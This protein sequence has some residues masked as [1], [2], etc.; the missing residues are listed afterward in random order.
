MVRTRSHEAPLVGLLAALAAF[1]ALEARGGQPYSIVGQSSAET[2]ATG[3]RPLAERI[4]SANRPIRVAAEEELAPD[5]GLIPSLSGGATFPPEK[6]W[7]PTPA[8]IEMPAGAATI[9]VVADEATAPSEPAVVPPPEAAALAANPTTTDDAGFIDE[10]SSIDSAATASEGLQA[11]ASDEAEAGS[12]VASAAPVTP[13]PVK[14]LPPRRPQAHVTPQRREALLARLRAA[15]ADMPHPLGIVPAAPRRQAMPRQA[16][17]TPRHP[18]PVGSTPLQLAAVPEAAMP[19]AAMPEIAASEAVVEERGI[20]ADETCSSDEVPVDATLPSTDGVD[21]LVSAEA[22]NTEGTPATCDAGT[23][24][25]SEEPRD[26]GLTPEGSVAAATLPDESAEVVGDAAGTAGEGVESGAVGTTTASDEGTIL[27]AEAS[28]VAVPRPAAPSRQATAGAHG[29]RASGQRF[30]A[31]ATIVQRSGAL[32]RLQAR[33]ESIP[34]PLGLLP[35]PRPS[36]HAGGAARAQA[37]VARVAPPAQLQ[38]KPAETLQ[39]PA[40]EAVAS[41]EASLA[42]AVHEEHATGVASAE[43][44][45][46]PAV[47][48]ADTLVAEPTDSGSEQAPGEG[49]PAGLSEAA[50]ADDG[51]AAGAPVEST[52]TVVEESAALAMTETAPGLIAELATV[53]APAEVP[54]A[55]R[56]ATAPTGV[57]RPSRQTQSPRPA[58]R[59]VVQRPVRDRLGAALAAM[60]RPL[61]LLP[62]PEVPT[63]RRAPAARPSGVS[64]QAVANRH[65]VPRPLDLTPTTGAAPVDAAAT[66]PVEV[67]EGAADDLTTLASGNDVHDETMPREADSAELADDVPATLPVDPVPGEIATACIEVTVAGP[68]AATVVGEQVRLR[69]TIRN[70]GNAPAAAVTPVL[71]FAAGLEPVGMQGRHGAVSAEGSVVFDRCPELAAGESVEVEVIAACTSPGTILY[72][73]VAWCGEGASAEQVPVDGEVLV[74]PTRLAVEPSALPRR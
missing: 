6:E 2:A 17:Q 47:V 39:V 18:S 42:E 52:A 51:V 70:T 53:E 4:K 56:T 66:M 1:C 16:R 41:V 14:V 74:V 68:E 36:M 55:L 72:Q 67:G 8:V 44:V 7:I 45:A 21:G 32:D 64:P 71:H 23:C 31:P 26:A 24:D 33:L 28:A 5:R 37:N 27:K 48:S 59:P 38:P 58:P 25:S 46:D 12:D 9:E 11:L 19:E 57:A 62:S 50:L 15:L 43:P 22:G 3:R 13:K 29:A 30:R 63:A 69:F 35:A 73:G 40:E 34:R 60:P 49:G 10:A 20:A 54:P 65:P 61:G